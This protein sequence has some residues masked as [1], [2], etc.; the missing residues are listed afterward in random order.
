MKTVTRQTIAHRLAAVGFTLQHT[1]GNC[2]A[3]V[4]S[5][6]DGNTEEWITLDPDSIAPSRLRDRCS[7]SSLTDARTADAAW[8]DV[9]QVA[10]LA[11]ILAILEA[12]SE[13]ETLELRLANRPPQAHIYGEGL[14]PCR[15]Y[16]CTGRTV[17]R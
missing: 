16:R 12:P 1:G 4:R 8:S 9:P 13:Y 15:C 14:T 7:V 6:D 3:Y 11:E 5:S 2:T 10:T 17:R